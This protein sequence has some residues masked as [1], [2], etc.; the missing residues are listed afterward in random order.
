M[1][2]RKSNLIQRN[3]ISGAHHHVDISDE[4]EVSPQE[5]SAR[6]DARLNALKAAVDADSSKNG[7]MKSESQHPALGDAMSRLPKPTAN[8]HPNAKTKGDSRYGMA[9]PDRT[10]TKVGRDGKE[11]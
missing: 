10:P 9:E 1:G 11:K 7:V 6:S 3:P 5:L 2:Y 4:R 8:D